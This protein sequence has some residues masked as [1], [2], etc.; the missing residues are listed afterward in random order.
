MEK[1]GQRFCDDCGKPIP[2]QAK[3]AEKTAEGKDRCLACQIRDAQITKG[4]RH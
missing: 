3:L 4:L 2:L 1:D